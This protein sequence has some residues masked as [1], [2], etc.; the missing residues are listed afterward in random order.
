[1]SS[2]SFEELVSYTRTNHL[3][4]YQDMW[5]QPADLAL[6]LFEDATAEEQ[7]EELRIIIELSRESKYEWHTLSRIAQSALRTGQPLP[8]NLADW[9][10]DVLA[11]NLKRPRTGSKTLARDMVFCAEVE[12]LRNRFGLTLTR[13][14]SPND[15]SAFEVVAEASGYSYKTVERAWGLRET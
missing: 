5:E 10:A 7:L 3:D 15:W 2:P 6:L 13:S 11:K 1:M 8:Q 4:R 9:V 14:T 12:D